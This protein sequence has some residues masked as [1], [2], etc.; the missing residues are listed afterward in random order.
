MTEYCCSEFTKA[1]D[2]DDFKYYRVEE[3]NYGAIIK[4]GW[5]IRSA[6]FDRP[7]ASLKPFKHCPWCAAKL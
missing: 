4:P 7:I 3:D 6:E 2:Y 5:Y 1:V